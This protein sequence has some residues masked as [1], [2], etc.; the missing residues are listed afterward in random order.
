MHAGCVASGGLAEL[1]ADVIGKD[2]VSLRPA[3]AA[4]TRSASGGRGAAVGVRGETGHSVR[5]AP[6]ACRMAMPVFALTTAHRKDGRFAF[7]L[8]WR[9]TAVVHVVLPVNGVDP[10]AIIQTP[11]ARQGYVGEGRGPAGQ[12]LASYF[13]FEAFASS[14]RFVGRSGVAG[15]A[16][17]A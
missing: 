5:G 8:S 11:F 4:R 14:V 17:V 12:T 9:A 1:A 13:P 10:A 3:V 7:G 16:D 6:G 2:G 15:H